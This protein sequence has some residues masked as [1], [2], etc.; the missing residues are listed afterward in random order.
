MPGGDFELARAASWFRGYVASFCARD[1]EAAPV[2][3]MKAAHTGRVRRIARRL[4]A[5]EGLHSRTVVLAEMAG[6]LL[7]R[8]GLRHK[9]RA[10]GGDRQSPIAM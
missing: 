10:R 5:A 1:P 8:S 2:Y 7:A 6:L 4:A 9:R 3:R